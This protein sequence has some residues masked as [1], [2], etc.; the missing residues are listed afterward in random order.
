[1]ILRPKMKNTV[2]VQDVVPFPD[3]GYFSKKLDPKIM[4]MG[5][6]YHMIHAG[7]HV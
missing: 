4:K 3:F 1:M 6:R 5:K 7:I 2:F